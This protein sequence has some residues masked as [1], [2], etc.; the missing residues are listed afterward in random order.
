VPT[1]IKLEKE[2]INSMGGDIGFLFRSVSFLRVL[3]K[4][5]K[6]K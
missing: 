1:I 2:I 6:K 3:D 4:E 5:S